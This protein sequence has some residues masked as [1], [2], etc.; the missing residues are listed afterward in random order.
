ML[1][2]LLFALAMVGQGSPRTETDTVKV[3]TRPPAVAP[4]P[5]PAAV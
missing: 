3:A 4:A 1:T 2:Q 5:R